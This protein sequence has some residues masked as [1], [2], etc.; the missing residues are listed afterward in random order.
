MTFR[1]EDRVV[2][3]AECTERRPRSG[4]VREVLREDPAPRYRIA[5]DDGTRAF[6]HRRPEHCTPRVRRR[7]QAADDLIA[8]GNGACGRRRARRPAS[9]RAA[10][11]LWGASDQSL[12][13]AIARMKFLRHGRIVFNHLGL[14]PVTRAATRDAEGREREAPP[15][16]RRCA[17]RR[18][19]ELAVVLHRAGLRR[20]R[21]GLDGGGGSKS[22]SATLTPGR[23]RLLASMSTAS[24]RRRSGCRPFPRRCSPAEQ[25]PIALSRGPDGIFI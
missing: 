8:G 14:L 9:A 12:L 2:A 18:R 17:P 22:T 6:T 25:E 24:L 21:L 16:L 1:I 15:A 20:V 7:R 5:F 10:G 13:I 11:R 3:E 4:T 19:P 23:P